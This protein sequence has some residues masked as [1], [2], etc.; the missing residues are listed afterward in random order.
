MSFQYTIY[1]VLGKTLYTADTLSR[2]PGDATTCSP[3]QIET[4]VQEI[5]ATLLAD[6]IAYT[7][8][9]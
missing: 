1:H 2:A 9:A 4:F 5:T 3:E 6:L 8:T 7:A